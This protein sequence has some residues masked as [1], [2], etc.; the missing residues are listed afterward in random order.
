MARLSCAPRTQT[1][2]QRS[3]EGVIEKK[4][5][6]GLD[7]PRSESLHCVPPPYMPTYMED[8]TVLDPAQTQSHGAVLFTI[9][10]H[11]TISLSRAAH[12]LLLPHEDAVCV[13]PLR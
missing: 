13:A 2:E 7:T 6:P 8:V 5:G 12:R 1:E 3:K 10:Q 9:A 4:R 11:K